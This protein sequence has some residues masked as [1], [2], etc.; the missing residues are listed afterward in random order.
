MG[1]SLRLDPT[2]ASKVG[3]A[4]TNYAGE[5]KTLLGQIKNVNDSLK[6]EWEGTDAQT[7]ADKVAEQAE[8]MQRLQTVIEETGNQV[9]SIVKMYQEAME[10]NK[11]K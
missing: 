8:V 1:G 11:V 2:S 3:N 7:Y 4:I 9:L 10:S 5:F 6:S